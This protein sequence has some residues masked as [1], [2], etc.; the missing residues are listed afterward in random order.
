MAEADGSGG[1][2]TQAGVR[3]RA[4]IVRAAATVL[5]REGYARLTA[6]KVAAEAGMSL[7]HISYNFSGMDEV[8]CE[9]CRLASGRLRAATERQVA[10][11]G[12]PP[13][14]RLEGF[15]RAGF[16]EEIL[17]P[18]HL[19]LRIDLWSAALVNPEL[20]ATELDLYSHY[21][22]DLAGLLHE[23]LGPAGTARLPALCDVIMATL[24]GLWLDWMR[25]RDPVAVDHAIAA[26]L[27]LVRGAV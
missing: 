4:A 23:V 24:D 17:D 7:G 8:L 1:G 26:L 22:A 3:R 27:A 21:R 5:Q 18:H 12:A 10:A 15:L 16:T 9:A 13:L 20:A 11:A 2:R 14:A 19:R 6:R 25:R